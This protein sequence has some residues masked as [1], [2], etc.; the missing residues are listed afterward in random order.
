[1]SEHNALMAGQ[2]ELATAPVMSV[3]YDTPRAVAQHC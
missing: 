3:R 2:G 1:M